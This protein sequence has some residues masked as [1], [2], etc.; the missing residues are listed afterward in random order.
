[1]ACA[2]LQ[3]AGLAAERTW[4]ALAGQVSDEKWSAVQKLARTGLASPLT[5]SMGRLFDAVAALCGLR[6][7]VNY[8]G[9]AAIELERVAE[10]TTG[11]YPLPLIPTDAGLELDARELVRAVAE[12]V[13]A[14]LPAGVIAGRFHE[15]VAAATVDACVAAAS[16]YGTEVV[17]LS[18]GVF[19]NRG[20]L[21]TTGRRLLAAGLRVLIPERLPVGDGGIAYGQ[22]AVA[23][24]WEV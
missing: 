18:G 13:A 3:A 9:Q 6:A 10:D 11:G 12:D 20:L 24:Q 4:P 8:E 15:G 5:S 16:R 22:A 17:V 19:A 23:N 2:W 14:G 7:E 21:Q 1:M